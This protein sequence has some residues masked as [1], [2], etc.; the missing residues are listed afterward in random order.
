[1]EYHDPLSRKQ[2][3]LGVTGSIAAYKAVDILRRLQERGADV[4]VAMTG[5]AE[6]FI[7]RLTFETLSGRPVL[8]DEFGG[9]DRSK[10]GHIEIT[11]GLD[12]ALIA[13]ATANFIGKMASGI[14]DDALTSAVM[15][16]ACPLLIAPAMNDRMFRN[17]VLQRNIQVLKDLGTRFIEPGTGSLACGT[18]GQGRLADVDRIIHELASLMVP[19]DLTGK[20]VLV[21]AGPT[22]EA[23][24]AVRFITNPSSGK[25]GYALAHAARMRG[26]NVVLVTGPTQIPPPRDIAIIPVVNADH[27]RRAVLD[28]LEQSDV[29]IMAAAV[30]DFRPR[31][32]SDRK[33]KKSEAPLTLDLERTVDILQEIGR[34]PGK[35]LLVGFA[36]ETDNVVKNAE[37]KLREKN[38]GLIV[39]NDVLKTGSGFGTDTNSVVII[40]HRGTRVELPTM[41]KSEIAARVLDSVVDLLQQ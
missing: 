29:V 12:A 7:S 3:L 1:V 36:A 20:T 39:V 4:R 31:H 32:A 22:H 17:P 35:R 19:K 15:A 41:P 23:I 24:D 37:N 25:M 5:N 33:V 6:H 9:A 27:M 28:H 30:S 10:I 21:T 34:M 13:P 11:E 40:D 26:A 38:L 2:I 8:C 14:A 18:I 16:L